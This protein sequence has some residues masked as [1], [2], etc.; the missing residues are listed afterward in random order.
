M[1]SFKD[2]ISIKVWLKENI[3]TDVPH[4]QKEKKKTSALQ[5]HHSSHVEQKHA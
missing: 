3:V 2:V 4:A 5:R 1:F